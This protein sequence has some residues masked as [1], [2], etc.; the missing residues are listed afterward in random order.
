MAV[1][2]TRYMLLLGT[3]VIMV[4]HDKKICGVYGNSFA[5]DMLVMNSQSMSRLVGYFISLLATY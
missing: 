5:F 3:T 4:T 2:D 1:T